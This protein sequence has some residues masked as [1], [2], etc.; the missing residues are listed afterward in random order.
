MPT[1]GSVATQHCW[2]RHWRQSFHPLMKPICTTL[3][4][5]KSTTA[6]WGRAVHWLLTQLRVATKAA[7]CFW[8]ASKAAPHLG[9][10]STLTGTCRLH[11]RSRR[12]DDS[13][14]QALRQ[15]AFAEFLLGCLLRFSVERIQWRWQSAQR[16]S[17]F[18]VIKTIC[19][20]KRSWSDRRRISRKSTRELLF[21]LQ[22]DSQHNGR[23]LRT[24]PASAALHTDATGLACGAQLEIPN[25][26]KFLARGFC[27]GL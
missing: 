4:V 26:S 18:A 5:L 21:W 17:F 14:C 15:P 7:K 20:G 3:S 6:L 16:I 2:R 23:T 8:E 24:L 1:A 10:L 25:C 9:G 11:P 27:A 22:L 19:G 12:K 13:A